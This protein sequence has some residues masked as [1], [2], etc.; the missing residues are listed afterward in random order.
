MEDA[1]KKLEPIE[2][3]ARKKVADLKAKLSSAG[4]FAKSYY[5]YNLLT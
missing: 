1:A 3:E 4:A 5:S 2:D